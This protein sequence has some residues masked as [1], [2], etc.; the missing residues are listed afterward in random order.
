[1]LCQASALCLREFDLSPI[2]GGCDEHD[3]AVPLCRQQS[4]QWLRHTFT[5]A[6]LLRGDNIPNVPTSITHGNLKPTM[7]FTEQKALDNIRE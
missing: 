5:I 4:S 3:A 2:K 7:D 1:L 6:A